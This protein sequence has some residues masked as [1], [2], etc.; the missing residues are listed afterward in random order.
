MAHRDVATI[1]LE[2]HLKMQELLTDHHLQMQRLFASS[3]LTERPERVLEP[4]PEEDTSGVA[5]MTAEDYRAACRPL[6]EPSTDNA[7][8]DFHV[9]EPK[10]DD[11]V[12]LRA[13]LDEEETRTEAT[14]P[15]PP[16]S[17]TRA[18]ALYHLDTMNHP[19][20][21]Q[22]MEIQRYSLKLGGELYSRA[23][24]LARA[25]GKHLWV[26]QANRSLQTN[27]PTRYDLNTIIVKVDDPDFNHD[28]FEPSE[29]C[30]VTD[31]VGIGKLGGM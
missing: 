13:Q 24:E 31:V 17:A 12:K 16:Q 27:P 23:E 4:V 9:I 10:S 30:V 29:R 26:Y 2:H 11:F 5:E 7:I 1:L 8:D 18:E 21:S 15:D 22:R 14:H 25:N 6:F 19:N 3:A 20:D 28:A